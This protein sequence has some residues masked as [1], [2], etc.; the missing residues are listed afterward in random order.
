MFERIA[1]VNRGEP[2]RR[3]IH[4]AQELAVERGEPIRTIALHTEAERR[5]A[6]V[7]EADEAFAIGGAGNPY[8][9]LGELER[10]LRESRADAA[11]VGWGFVAEDPA[12]AELCDR[13]GVAFVGPPPDVMRRLGDKIGAKLLAEEVGVPVAAWSGG[14]VLRV[15]DAFRHAAA[16]G[17]P[18]MIKAT[19]GGGGRG[20]RMVSSEGELPVA[21]E[22]ARDEARRSFGDPTVLMERVVSGARHVEVQVIA[23]HHGNAWAL[24]VRDCSI[25]RRNQ[26]LIEESASAALDPDQARDLADSALRLVRAAE[27]RNAGTVEFLYEP[28]GR[29]FAFLEVNTRLQVEHPVTEATCGVD[30]VKLQLLI[31]SGAA[32]AGDPP[33]ERGHAIEARLNTED[34]ERG[35]AP[36]PGV[37]R[38]LRFP[39]GPGIR[40]DTGFVEGDEIPSDYDSMIAKIVAWGGDRAEAC[41]RLRRALMET[42]VVV[43]GGATNR[44]FLLHLLDRPEVVAGTADTG[45]LDRLGASDELLPTRH[46]EVALLAAA[47]EGH[48]SEEAIERERFYASARR[49]RPTASDD[50]NPLIELRHRGAGYRLA[51]ARLGPERYRVRVGAAVIDVR[52]EHLGPFEQRLGIGG[53]THRV[54]LA[55]SPPD[56]L[57]EVDGVAHRVSRDEGGL[58]RAPAPALVVAIAVAAGDEVEAGDPI[59]VLESM[60]M[61]TTLTAPFA[62]RVAE[63]LVAGNVQ[64]GAG[65]PVVR[66]EVAVA[67]REDQP[68]Q[69]RLRFEAESPSG[70]A[71]EQLLADLRSLILG[72]DIDA[73]EGRDLVARLEDSP[74]APAPGEPVLLQR[75]LDILS[76]FADLAELSRDRPPVEQSSSEEE[77]VHSPREHFHGFLRSLDADREGV[78]EPLRRSLVRALGHYGVQDLTRS[79]ELAQ[80]CFRIFLAHRR[81][82]SQLPAV[83]ALLNRLLRQQDEPSESVREELR[84]TLDRLIVATQLRHPAIGEL[85]RRVRFSLFDLPTVQ[86]ARER[87]HTQVSEQLDILA[88]NP[89]A[90]DY[91]TRIETVV[92]SPYPLI[93]LLGERLM[94]SSGPDE[95]LLEVLT[96]RYYKIREL[97][98]VRRVD[99]DG[100]GFIT[101]AYDRDGRQVRLVTTLADAGEIGAAAAGIAAVVRDLETEDGGGVVADIYVAWADSP[102]DPDAMSDL[103]AADLSA[104]NLSTAV[105]RVAVAASDPTGGID[106]HFTFRRSGE[107]LVEESVVR[108]LHPMIARRL[109]LW[110]LERFAL[111]RLPSVED[112]YLFRCVAP[113]GGDERLVAL[114]EVRDLEPALDESGALVALPEVER[115]LANCLEGIRA[116]QGQGRALNTNHVFLYVWPQVDVRLRDLVAVA[117]RRLAPMTAGLGLEEV[118][119]HVRTGD[120]E[121]GTS[122][123]EVALSFSY[124]PGAG[125]T[126]SLSEPPDEPLAVLDA[127][128]QRKLPARR[129]GA[130]YPYELIPL[131]AGSGGSF[132]EYDL[133]GDGRLV[134]VDRPPGRNEAGIVCG[135]VDTPTAKYPDGIRRLVLMGDPTSSLGSVSEPECRRIIGAIDL[136][137]QLRIPVEWFA[138]S[139][140]AKI[141][142]DSGTENMDWVARALRRIVTFTQAG[143]EVNVVVAGINVGAQ[144][145]W[146]AEAT[147]LMHTRGILVMTPDSAMVLTGKQALDYSGGVSAEDN[148]GIGGFDRIMGPNGQA[149]YWAPHLAGACDILFAYYDHSY[150][151]PGERFARRVESA[152]PSDR[153]VCVWPLDGAPGDFSTV[154]D[155]FSAATNAERKRP[156]DIRPV[157]R[158]VVDQDR[159]PLERWAGMADAET[160]VVFD[161][162]LGGRP[163]TLIGF[164][165]RPMP[166]RGFLP[167]D[168][169][170]QWTAGTL[171]PLSSKKVAR[172]INAASGSR[173]VV[174]LAN[175]SGFDG[176]PESLRKWQLEYGA[177]IGRAVVNFDGPVVFCVISRYHGGAFVVFSGALHDNM[178]VIAIEGSYASVI[179]GAP[180]AAVVFAR[181]VD[182]RTAADPRVAELEQGLVNAGDDERARLAAQLAETRSAVRSEKLGEVATDFD[183]LHSIQRAKEV[184][185][186]HAIIPAS[187]LRPYLIEAVERGIAR[188]GPAAKPAVPETASGMVRP[189]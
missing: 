162:H 35:F 157:I 16:I 74:R 32:L 102:A 163:V 24:G 172:G 128:D 177:E 158:A 151:A 109:R 141:S 23:D 148:F 176:S 108:G 82:A 165:S 36:A 49:G 160:A 66:L 144:P 80:A 92:A 14:P 186:V 140:G 181:D 137:E 52:L 55:A 71:N 70:T 95:P 107:Q 27:Y 5:A 113:D 122:R 34:P 149:Q 65:A 28:S 133:D 8:L 41:A 159:E 143:G 175:L 111:E 119:L 20:I 62:G 83:A 33:S 156:F 51:V 152:D 13:L 182:A 53:R 150:V 21:F 121:A 168:G 170:D 45:W 100:R 42:S 40:V 77:R 18:L 86:A 115:I 130:V 75:E 50:L 47:I 2:A 153:D 73:R 129:R 166:R 38:R 63:V 161:A 26:K 7:R 79:P 174:V 29:T 54:I 132:I 72:Y 9:D 103:I 104:A 90:P 48:D 37:L 12:F 142:R 3:L 10:A 189:A 85:A 30:L 19:A 180:A 91:A 124:Q 1:I 185:S 123:A 105:R 98:D 169:P 57:V 155:I 138:L 67:G 4:A 25:Q 81:A 46:G 43:D 145:Y 125:V 58:I 60:K 59:V 134:P 120:P 178:E 188:T 93:G 6:F 187:A 88:A 22:R 68:D 84:Q 171:F 97:R 64:V 87:E 56:Q 96:R 184:G 44:A 116:A 127:Y 183:R 136:A 106:R 101:A 139:S 31:A 118:L 76:V 110:R 17:Y 154:G 78:P 146:N 173:P 61:E 117:R 39:S 15:E 112:T 135:L 99:R 164:E 89:G 131:I 147:M 94:R 69:P 126:A 114:A 167:A 179:G 11:W